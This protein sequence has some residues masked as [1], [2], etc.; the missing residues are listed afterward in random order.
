MK[1]NNLLFVL[2]LTFI[3]SSVAMSQT[4]KTNITGTILEEGTNSPIEQATVR[5]L[6]QKDS[7]FISGCVSSTSGNFTIKNVSNG[8]YI[9][10]ISYVGFEDIY[11]NVTV[12]GK[13]NPVSLGK[14][15]LKDAAVVLGVAV[16]TGK[17]PEVVLRN[18]TLEFNA[19]SYKVQEGAV[20]ED[21]LKKMPGV[22]VSSD[23][24]I[25][26]NGKTISKIMV[27]GE[28]FF[29]NDPKIA[30]KNLPSKMIDKI[31]VLDKKSDMA[32]MTGFDDGEEETIINLTVKPDMKKGLFGQLFGGYG[33]KDRYEGQGMINRFVGND[34]YTIMGGANNTNNMGST[35]L[36]AS[37]IPGMGGMRR[38][39]RGG[40]AG[41]GI[42][43]SGFGAANINKKFNDALKLNGGVSYNHSNNTATS[44][45]NQ[46]NTL[47]D[48]TSYY[49]EEN[50]NVSKSDGF[51]ANLRLEWTP[52]TLTR[53]IF[54]P[55]YSFSKN[56]QNEIGEFSTFNEDMDTVNIG[57]S[58]YST[59]GRAHNINASL[60]FSR[61]L[62]SRGR[63]LSVSLSGGTSNS[64]NKGVNYSNTEYFMRD[65]S[66]ES[67]DLVDQQFR[68]DNSGF[69][70]RA[71]VSWV[72]PI[73]HNNFI[74]ASYSFSQNKQ[75]SLK[76][77][78]VPDE[79][80]A[81]TVLDTAYSQSYRNNFINQ[82]ISIAFKSQREKFN[83]TIGFN[84]DPSYSKSE[85]FVGDTTLTSLSRSVVNLSPMAQFRYRF[86]RESS[87][88]ID[89]N[90][91][92]NQP[93]MEQLQ[94]VADVS[95]PLN[96]TIGNPSLKPTYVNNVRVEYNRFNREKQQAMIFFA[97]GQYTI[98][99][100][101][102]KSTYDQETG[103]QTS[104]YENVDGNY[105]V[106]LRGMLNTP[107]KNKRF[108]I[109]TSTSLSLNNQN[110][111]ID[112]AKN[113]NKNFVVNENAGIRFQ[114]DIIDL[115][116]NGRFSYN[117]S[118][119]SL[120]STQN[121]SVYNYGVGGNTTI[122][123]PWNMQIDSDINWSANAGYSA[124]FD[125][126]QILWNASFSKSF[127]KGNQ[128]TLRFKIYDILQQR[129]N[130]SRTIAGNMTTDYEYNTLT[131][132]FIV[133]FVYRFSIFSGGGSAGGPGPGGGPRFGGSGGPPPPRF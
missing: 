87:L 1:W 68:L 22:E 10:H 123:L 106:S 90:G 39:A 118:K 42:T 129:S 126:K 61:K 83:Y 11:K 44:K 20:L 132:Y 53:L 30:S 65:P 16:V 45:S 36:G 97:N 133:H 117:L 14:L 5:L 33:N 57:N 89:Y 64:F 113:T 40:G 73:G 67:N 38:G 75:E 128:A 21:V 125:Q 17:A 80:G 3:F 108:S 124:G 66:A 55:S 100:I 107:L 127:L 4:N 43:K 122:Y 91:S 78:Y 31:Q 26:V 27:D 37:M 81:Y 34:R 71:Y 120:Q 72:E 48:G 70:Y 58:A 95:D 24:Q 15:L 85:N 99:D 103:R 116:V 63:V 114:S 105:N 93:S 121:Q 86:S 119:N 110:T 79:S 82:R 74:Q 62:N 18:D 50:S 47:T 46:T 25:T 19:D 102:R 32:Q 112:G 28:E 101:V 56:S 7:A 111:F 115:G 59:N 60:E 29:S 8:K 52:D 35:D 92:T 88:R 6:Q 84:V 94:P 96:V 12:T 13:N 69:N 51:S 131:S 77:S 2:C 130:I 9:V 54:R 98:N 41:N 49:R 76:N 23:G 104:T 109:N